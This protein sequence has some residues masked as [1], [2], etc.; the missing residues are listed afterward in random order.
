MLC[1]KL[2][3]HVD[4]SMSYFCFWKWGLIT[5]YYI[6]NIYLGKNNL[7]NAEKHTHTHTQ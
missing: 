5:F 2:A 3:L 4:T 7:E 1:L 6:G